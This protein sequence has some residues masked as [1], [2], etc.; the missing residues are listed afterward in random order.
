MPPDAAMIDIYDQM[1]ANGVRAP[2]VVRTL[3]RRI[4]V[5]QA[6]IDHQITLVRLVFAYGDL[7]DKRYAARCQAMRAW[8]VMACG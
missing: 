5:S 1:R 7:M 6:E 8:R 4:G 2:D 3:S